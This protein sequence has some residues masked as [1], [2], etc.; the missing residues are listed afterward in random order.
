M[1]HWNNDGLLEDVA[2]GSAAGVVG[3]YR[4]RYARTRSGE[5]FVLQQGRF[6]GRPSELRVEAVGTPQAVSSVKVG[7]NV[8]IVGSGLLSVLPSGSSPARLRQAAAVL[9]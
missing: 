3:A 9:G 4:M 5:R 8:S 7:G 1:R 6:I 2:T